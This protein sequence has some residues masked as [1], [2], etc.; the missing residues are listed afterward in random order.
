ME[1]IRHFSD[2][3]RIGL[4]TIFDWHGGL[5]VAEYLQ[6]KLFD[7]ILDHPTFCSDQKQEIRES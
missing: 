1:T 4:F 7:V 3:G 6:Q 5:E 2:G